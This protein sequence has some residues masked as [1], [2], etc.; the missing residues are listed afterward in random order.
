M[1]SKTADSCRWLAR[2]IAIA[3]SLAFGTFALAGPLEDGQAAWNEGHFAKA[4]EILRPLADAGNPAAQYRVGWMY[5]TGQGVPEDIAEADKWFKAA[6]ETGHSDAMFSLCQDFALGGG[7]VQK[8]SL[9]AYVWCDLA[10]AAYTKAKRS[11]AAGNAQSMLTLI[12]GKLTADQLV[13]AKA[14]VTRW[15]AAHPSN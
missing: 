3:L 12:S 5:D 8:D 2:G 14:Q 9:N 13:E 11:E 15:A 10:A 7:N 4:M 6:A 1:S